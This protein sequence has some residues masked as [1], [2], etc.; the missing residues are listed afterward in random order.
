MERRYRAY[1]ARESQC[2]VF[3]ALPQVETPASQAVPGRSR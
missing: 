1:F 3:V 2:N